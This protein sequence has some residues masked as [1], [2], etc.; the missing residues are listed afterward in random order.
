MQ[1]KTVIL[2]NE[3]VQVLGD[4]GHPKH[5]RILAA[6]QAVAGRN[7]RKA[8]SAKLV[9]PTCV[10]VEAGWIRQAAG[11]AAINRLRAEDAPLDAASADRAAGVRADLG[12]SV[13]DAHLAAVLDVTAGPHAVLTSDVDDLRRI[14]HHLDI[15]LNIVPV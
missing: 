8:G 4:I 3:A 14:A 1:A 9:V 5:R 7:R 12:V 13:T 10:R 2:D 15:G 11:G 6:L